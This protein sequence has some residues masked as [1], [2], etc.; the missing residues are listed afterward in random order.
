MKINNIIGIIETFAAVPSLKKVH[1]TE[2]GR[3]YFNENDAKHAN[4][5]TTKVEDGEAKHTANKVVYKSFAPDAKELTDAYK[6]A[7]EPA[8]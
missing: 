6:A 7:T 8:K 2:D 5:V 4:G 3:H 1:I